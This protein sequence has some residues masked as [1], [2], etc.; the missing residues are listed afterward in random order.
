[1]F[2]STSGSL[3]RA[4]SLLLVLFCA[5]TVVLADDGDSLAHIEPKDTTPN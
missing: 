5:V 2:S 1:M 3:A 4:V